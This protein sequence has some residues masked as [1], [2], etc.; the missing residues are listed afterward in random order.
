[1]TLPAEGTQRQNTNLVSSSPNG[2][3]GAPLWPF[4]TFRY[5]AEFI[6]QKS[7]LVFMSQA[8]LF[9]PL[10]F[11]T[12]IPVWAGSY[13]NYEGKTEFLQHSMTTHG[14]F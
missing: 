5:L 1:M 13:I 6:C 10:C 3:T 11:I 4:N 14:Q 12:S 2:I 9:A 8:K 7:P